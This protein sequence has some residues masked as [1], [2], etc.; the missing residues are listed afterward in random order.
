[1]PV[2][3]QLV[4][5]GVC[6]ELRATLRLIEQRL[7]PPFFPPILAMTTSSF[8]A[9]SIPSPYSVEVAR[10]GIE[11]VELSPRRSGL[12]SSSFGA[13]EEAEVSILQHNSY[14]DSHHAHDIDFLPPP[15]SMEYYDAP[16][17]PS[18]TLQKIQQTQAKVSFPLWH[19]TLACT[20]KSISHP[21]D[22]HI[23]FTMLFFLLFCLGLLCSCQGQDSADCSISFPRAT[24]AAV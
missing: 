7:P 19:F 3:N 6:E 16:S 20:K 10:G 22:F 14:G 13:A 12:F 24:G 5:V 8:P 15:V 18:I 4:F 17:S 23:P 21:Y 11:G 2:T 1:M 9:Q